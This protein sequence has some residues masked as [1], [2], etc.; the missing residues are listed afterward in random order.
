[1]KTF[2]RL[3]NGESFAFVARAGSTTIMCGVHKAYEQWFGYYECDSVLPANCV[4]VV[5][6]PIDRFRSLLS[7]VY[8][9]ADE[10]ISR[11]KASS[12]FPCGRGYLQHFRPVSS[13]LQDDSQI[14]RFFSSDVWNALK[15][16]EYKQTEN[17]SPYRPEL[18]Q[19]QE[20]VIKKIYAEDIALWEA[21]S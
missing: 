19:D 7:A 5:R 13:I 18:T 3:P 11:I 9:T 12:R 10:A 20:N 16:P 2:Y 21:L 6:E 15:I 1:M 4:V 17:K 8:T 14:F